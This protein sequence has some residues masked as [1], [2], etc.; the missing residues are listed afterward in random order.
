MTLYYD[1]DNPLAYPHDQV[2]E[3]DGCHRSSKALWIDYDGPGE[4]AFCRDCWLR[5]IERARERYA[6]SRERRMT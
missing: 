4:F 1:E 5:V 6:V 2:G 3:C